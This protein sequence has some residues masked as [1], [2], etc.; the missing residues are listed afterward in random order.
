MAANDGL[1]RRAS[2]LAGG[3]FGGQPQGVKK[4]WWSVVAMFVWLLPGVSA[5]E[6]VVFGAASLGEVLGEAASRFE[7]ETGTKVVLN[8]AGSNVLARQIEAGAPA[9][10]FFSADE[11]L[12]EQLV[13]AGS[14][15][16]TSVLALLSNR[17]VV[18]V[19]A[20]EGPA[21]QEQGPGFLAGAFVKRIALA[22]P[23]AVPA[24]R[25]AKEWLVHRGLWEKVR[26]RVIPTGNV[27]AALAAVAAGHADA[28]I[29]YRTDVGTTKVRI[30]YRVLQD[31]APTIRYSVGVVKELAHRAQAEAFL[32]FLTGEE[33][34]RVFK[35]A[36]FLML[37]REVP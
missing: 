10:V 4:E 1:Y 24:G 20:D 6:V 22:D 27:R 14:V 9:D 11:A 16:P 36:G 37:A 13:D 19:P 25:Y 3:V 12:M 32:A 21:S 8:L 15:E 5:E 33:M 17:L 35:E 2:S 23:E 29:V 18:I 31:E 7:A 26:G 30:V 34:R 28:G